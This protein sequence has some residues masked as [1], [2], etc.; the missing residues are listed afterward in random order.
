MSS[1]GWPSSHSPRSC[2]PPRIQ[3]T[4]TPLKTRGRTRSAPA[5]TAA[6]GCGSRRRRRRRSS[7]ARGRS[8]RVPPRRC[9]SPAS[10]GVRDGVLDLQRRDAGHD[11]HAVLEERVRER[12]VAGVANQRR[13]QEA[14]VAVVAAAVDAERRAEAAGAHAD[15]ARRRAGTSVRRRPPSRSTRRSYGYAAPKASLAGPATVAHDASAKTRIPAC[16]RRRAPCIAP[17]ETSSVEAPPVTE[18]SDVI[19]CANAGVPAPTTNARAARTRFMAIRCSA[20]RR[21]RR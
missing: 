18:T 11:V 3:R 21:R 14:A 19:G 16:R 15:R 17:A 13:A 9:V 4:S 2:N 6:C 12:P 10:P 20:A 1:N 8:D 7:P 5:G